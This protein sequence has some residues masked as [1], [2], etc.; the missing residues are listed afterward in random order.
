MKASA[1]DVHRRMK[2]K[3]RRNLRRFRVMVLT[4]VA[5]VQVP[6]IVTL[7]H[8][9][10]SWLWPLVGAVA[11]S[12]PFASTLRNPLDDLPKGWLFRWLGLWPFFVWWTA[13]LTFA[14]L[15]PL[16]WAI[17]RLAGVPGEAIFA[18]AGIVSLMA[19]MWA[20]MRRPRLTRLEVL[21]EGLPPQFD[22]YRI[23]Q[24][25]DIHCGPHT[26]PDRVAR[27][28]QRIN[29]LDADLVAVTGD[30]IT[31]GSRYLEPVADALSGLRGRDGVYACMG[32]H[33]Y[34][35]DGDAF[36]LL[37]S[38]KGLRV[39]RNQGEL[40][41]RDGAQVFVGGVD[42][43]WTGRD[44]VEGTLRQRPEGVATILLAHD[45][46][47]FPQAAALE[48]ELTLSGHT[49]GGQ[50]AVPLF[51]RRLSL[52]RIITRFTAGLY[53]RDKS[54]LY[55]NRGAGTTG[56]PVRLGAPAEIALITLR[57]ATA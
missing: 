2:M 30:L 36:A 32:N 55:V 38:R 45:P 49:H 52:A 56:P 28:V 5:L 41:E 44:D 57:C 43:T 47:L 21:I 1:I 29:H 18:S 17:G 34:F 27:W 26:P 39:L 8:V 46:N 6:A 33:D 53:R 19:G 20:T 23:A 35:T 54:F 31:S 10:G 14:V 9:T 25:S 42:D 13:C 3:R 24:L 15:L 7:A 16:A 50:L 51:G 22:G 4:V 37:L 48:V 40:V 11:I 12:T